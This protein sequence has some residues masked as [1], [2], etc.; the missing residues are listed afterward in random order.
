M[1]NNLE[2]YLHSTKMFRIQK[3]NGISTKH[4][5]RRSTWTNSITQIKKHYT[6]HTTHYIHQCYTFLH[7]KVHLNNIGFKSLWTFNLQNIFTVTRSYF[8]DFNLNV[9]I[10]QC[11]HG[12][13]HPS[14]ANTLF[15]RELERSGV[16]DDSS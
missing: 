9:I 13:R 12:S 14:R 5:K 11:N 3:Q 7:D 15:W 2:L 6:G 1:K 4:G 8:S 16:Y 10:M